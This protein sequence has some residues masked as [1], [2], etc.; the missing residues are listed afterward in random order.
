MQKCGI[1]NAVENSSCFNLPYYI[2]PLGQLVF[3]TNIM[4]NQWADIFAED[5]MDTKVC[6]KCGIEKTLDEFYAKKS[7][8]WILSSQ[9]RICIRLHVKLYQSSPEVKLRIREYTRE[10]RKNP[11]I[12][13]DRR[14]YNALPER[15]EYQRKH[16]QTPEG[17]ASAARSGHKRRALIK[18]LPCDLTA[19]QWE[20][21]KLE[22]NYRC[23]M[24]GE[25]K[26]LTRDHIV[27]VT[28]G[29]GFT[30]SNI[31]GLCGS[32]NSSKKDR[33]MGTDEL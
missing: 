19:E 4:V 33:I 30:K 6:T 22:Q 16:K 24:C 9:C 27:P 15:K 8:P 18:E 2:S 29:G 1:I 31:Q 11:K 3:S 17:R 25:E 5:K 20:E 32:C 14:R 21:I 12:I 26:P 10:Y 28:K 13:E 23:A 7:A